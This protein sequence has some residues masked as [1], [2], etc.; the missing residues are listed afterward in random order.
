MKNPLEA[1]RRLRADP[2]T[3]TTPYP[4]EVR[5]SQ[6]GERGLVAI[7][8][9]R[10]GEVLIMERPVV[11]TPGSPKNG[12]RLAWR[13]VRNLLE[14]P[15]KM[16][17]Y[18]NAGLKLTPQ[19][20]D[21]EDQ[22][23]A[24]AVAKK[25]TVDILFVE[26]LFH[27]VATNHMGYFDNSGKVAGTGLYATLC[28]SNHSC[29]PNA[30]PK[31]SLKQHWRHAALVAVRDVAAGE[32]ITWSYHDAAIFLSYGDRRDLLREKFGFWCRCRLCAIDEMTAASPA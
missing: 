21:E 3:M 29:S 23:E 28:F 22:K 19:N 14:N 16:A 4:C 13:I 17:W 7:S 11:W 26:T 27:T 15:E 30:M 32:E 6:D 10:L 2:I 12:A 1:A 24:E 9:V 25:Y 20:W 18:A 31:H 5:C 8:D